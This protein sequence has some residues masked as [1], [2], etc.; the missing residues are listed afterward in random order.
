M[1]RTPTKKMSSRA[2]V[3]GPAAREFPDLIDKNGTQPSDQVGSQSGSD[4]HQTV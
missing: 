2:A 4:W 3:H 1:V